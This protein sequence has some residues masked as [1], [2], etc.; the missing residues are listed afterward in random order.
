MQPNQ[1]LEDLEKQFVCVRVIQTNG[2][3]LKV[4]QYDYALSRSSM[5]LNA[6]LTIYGRY[7]MRNASG[8][9]S[10]SLLSQAGFRKTAERGFALHKSY[11]GNKEKLAA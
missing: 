6:D 9:N 7:G 10:D 3:D 5:F 1:D 11:P 8:P 4:F 2:L